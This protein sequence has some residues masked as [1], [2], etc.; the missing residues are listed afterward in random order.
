MRVVRLRVPEAGT[1]VR[2]EPAGAQSPQ[3]KHEFV[4]TV[5]YLGGDS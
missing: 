5:I 4:L 2:P 1:I 3:E